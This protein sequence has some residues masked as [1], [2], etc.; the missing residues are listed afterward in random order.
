MFDDL[1]QTLADT[2]RV[3]AQGSRACGEGSSAPRKVQVVSNTGTAAARQPTRISGLDRGTR[4]KKDVNFVSFASASNLE[5]RYAEAR[6]VPRPVGV[7]PDPPSPRSAERA[8]RGRNWT[9][10]GGRFGIAWPVE[11][12]VPAPFPVS[13]AD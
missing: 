2:P 6:W 10:R 5:P 1:S 12:Q 7:H 8:G 9:V 13:P 3:G 4:P 11:L